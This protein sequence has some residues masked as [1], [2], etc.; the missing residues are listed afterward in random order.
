LVSNI[1]FLVYV[2]Q[3]IPVS[4]DHAVGLRSRLSKPSDTM[5]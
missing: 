5:S 3:D 2:T 1:D 4:Y